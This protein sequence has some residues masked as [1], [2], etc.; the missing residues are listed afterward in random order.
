[1]PINSSGYAHFALGVPDNAV[2]TT[3]I[4]DSAVT[5]AKIAAGSVDSSKIVDGS[6]GASHVDSTQ[7]QRRVIESCDVGNAIR[8]I[9]DAGTV[10]CEPTGG[11][12][13]GGS[14][15]ANSV[16]KFT[17]TT[18]IGNSAITEVGGNVGIGTTTP[19]GRLAVRGNGTDVLLG[20]A[21][22]G[23]PTAAIGFGTMS[24]CTDFALGGNFSAG[25]DAGTFINRPTGRGIHFRENNGADQMTIAPGGNVGI[26]TTTPGQKLEVRDTGGG[27]AVFGISNG[28][29]VVGITDHIARPG[30]RAVS[31]GGGS[32]ANLGLEVFGR[33]FI[34]G[35]VGIGT[36]APDQLLSVNGNAS[37]VGGGT[38]LN[39]SDERLK[40]IHGMFD[41]GL[42]E[43]LKLRPIRYRY[44]QDNP[45]G[46]PDEGEHIGLSAQ[47]VQKVIPEA[48]TKNSQGYLMLNNDPVLWA[49]LNAIKE[50]QAQIKELKA[51]VE[52]LKAKQTEGRKI[53]MSPSP[54]DGEASPAG[55]R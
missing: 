3:N 49:M 26:G 28:V 27:A 12:G 15:T 9:N 24:G 13:I 45:V 44:N 37:K 5:S 2:T 30:V 39:F 19:A 46:I 32:P 29:G 10:I 31:A 21:G 33:A 40:A 25:A 43:I 36:G 4:Q 22:C 17:G 35:R 52:G 8:V 50:Q 11:G 14:G 54:L 20:D 41:A 6:I 55:T 42:E 7:V 53:A 34:S 38:W 1:M 23:P 47:E 16:P 51:E 48:V 18:T